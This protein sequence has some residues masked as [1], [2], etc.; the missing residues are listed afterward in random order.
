[1]IPS[2]ES[3]L[4]KMDGFETDY[5]K[6]LY[7]D[8][9]QNYIGQYK[10]YSNPRLCTILEGEKHVTVNHKKYVYDQSKSLIMPSYSKVIMEIEK[11]TKALVF[12]LSDTLIDQVLKQAK[13]DIDRPPMTNFNELIL[14]NQQYN[15][16][17]DLNA[18][19]QMGTE[20]RKRDRFLI[21]IYAQKL[22]Y[23]LLNNETTSK[24]LVRYKGH[25]VSQAIEIMSHSLDQKLNITDIA[26]LLNMSESNF[27]Q[28]FK[29]Y[30]GVTPQKFLHKLKLD[31]ALT[32][33]KDKSVTDVAFELGY[34]TPSH[35]I[36]LFKEMYKITPKQY[37]LKGMPL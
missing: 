9:P 1:M 26:A 2:L 7:Y 19:V 3:A 34:E 23:T 15:I 29:K 24:R 16:A 8:I 30:Y 14:N 5:V 22:V 6:I 33:L 28:Q 21:D 4:I 27:S 13:L 11:P 36:R 20:T 32:L 18:L 25:P 35:F 17:E 10:T 37:Q 12:E 31:T